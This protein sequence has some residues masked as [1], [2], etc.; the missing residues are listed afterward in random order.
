MFQMRCW[1]TVRSLG[2]GCSLCVLCSLLSTSMTTR[3]T[4]HHLDCLGLPVNL[5]YP[6]PI[7][8]FVHV[9]AHLASG[10]KIFG[11][12]CC[13]VLLGRGRSIITIP[14]QS[15]SSWLWRNAGSWSEVRGIFYLGTYA[16]YF[17]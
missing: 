6:M 3:S 15:N 8:I 11:S 7:I 5:V 9:F 1:L 10:N 12:G 16:L 14:V 13:G 4:L 17:Q 2:E